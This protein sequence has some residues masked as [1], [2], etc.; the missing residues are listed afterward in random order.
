MTATVL[1][2]CDRLQ[3]VRLRV[4]LTQRGRDAVAEGRGTVRCT[5]EPGRFPL[6]AR[7]SRRLVPGEATACVLA[8]TRDD[9]RQ[10]CKRV[11]LST[12]G[13][14]DEMSTRASIT[15]AATAVAALAAA[16]V[17]HGAVHT[18]RGID[19]TAALDRSARHA[20]VSGHIQCPQAGDRLV[21]RLELRQ[22]DGAR[23][24]GAVHTTCTGAVQSWALRAHAVGPVR[25]HAG[26]AEACAVAITSRHGV[27]T[28]RTQWC[29]PDG[30]TI[31]G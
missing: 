7:A 19:P 18:T 2:G 31:V 28:A 22:A 3:R 29:R 12:P 14:R 21:I 6:R 4:T 13:G 16:A 11:T 10:W 26:P 30:L 23:A 8:S 24:V 27:E 17:A 9:A 20:E 15:A 25:L 5:T 1:L